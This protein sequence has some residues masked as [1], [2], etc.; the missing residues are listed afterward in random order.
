MVFEHFKDKDDTPHKVHWWGEQDAKSTYCAS[1]C[2]AYLLEYLF[3]SQ[4][5][6]LRSM[7]HVE[8]SI[9]LLG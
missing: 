8:K 5:I 7:E 9:K 3:W 2:I 4:Q 1:S 6:W